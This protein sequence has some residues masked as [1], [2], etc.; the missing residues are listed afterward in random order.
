MD[1]HLLILTTV[2]LA[3]AMVS[4]QYSNEDYSSGSPVPPRPVIPGAIPLDGPPRRPTFRAQS[5]RFQA[6]PLD[7]DPA[8][9]PVATRVRRPNGRTAR[10]NSN[11]QP[12]AL[13]PLQSF[14]QL[15]ERPIPPRPV[16][17]EPEDQPAEQSLDNYPDPQQL[18]SPSGPPQTP[19][20]TQPIFPKQQALPR[21]PKPAAPP[22]F[23]PERPAFIPT[24]SPDSDFPV[25]S[26]QQFRTTAAPQPIEPQFTRPQ[27]QQNVNRVQQVVRNQP[28][29]QQFTKPQQYEKEREPSPPR[30]R[31]PVAQVLRK[32]REDNEDGSITWGFENDDGTF[33]E[34]TI[35]VDCVTRGKY[36]Y[37]DPDGVRRE[38][39]YSSGI[40]CDKTKQDNEEAASN[41][42]GYIDYQNN[43]YVLPNGDSVDL[44]KM[45]K[46]RAR[47]PVYRN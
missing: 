34:E 40:P 21:P 4:A 27:Q 11:V 47:K 22:A 2:M 25:P 45:V 9:L 33:K 18:G 1:G 36:G 37:V 38:Y 32:Y 10:I 3:L 39:S 28:P 29:K 15:E 23:R 41:S 16:V 30:E 42:E 44:D 46:N 12:S 26:R 43:R 14:Q 17:E 6:P 24:P 20:Y 19:L 31:K 35:G 7:A 5:R 13:P 8:P